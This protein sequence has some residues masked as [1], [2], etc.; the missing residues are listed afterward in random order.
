MRTRNARLRRKFTEMKKDNC[1]LIVNVCD[2]KNFFF[3][4]KQTLTERDR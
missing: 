3:K 4:K 1:F 2:E